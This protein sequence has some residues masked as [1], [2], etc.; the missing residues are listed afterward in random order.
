MEYSTSSKIGV[1]EITEFGEKLLI[2]QVCSGIL[3]ISGTLSNA[4]KQAMLDLEENN[5]HLECFE[6]KQL[7]V[8]ITRHELVPKHVTLTKEEKET[9][10]GK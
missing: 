3:I 9:L 4:A 7:Y 8:N 2:K 10:I 1:K 5:F 6:E